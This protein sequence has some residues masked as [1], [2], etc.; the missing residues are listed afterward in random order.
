MVG[1]YFLDFYLTDLSQKNTP[2]FRFQKNSKI[3]KIK[4]NT[5]GWYEIAPQL[6]E[7]IRERWL[8]DGGPMWRGRNKSSKISKSEDFLN[9][10]G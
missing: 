5:S 3:S 10:L 7:I 1:S 8:E 2:F 9:F 6:P 4:N